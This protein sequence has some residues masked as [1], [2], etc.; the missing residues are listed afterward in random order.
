[1]IY[2]RVTV[3]LYS[4]TRSVDTSR[5]ALSKGPCHF[6]VGGYFIHGTSSNSLQIVSSDP[7]L[8]TRTYRDIP[9]WTLAT[10]SLVIVIKVGNVLWHCSTATRASSGGFNIDSTR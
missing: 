5:A 4:V 2:Q 9:V 1:M 8:N 10:W 7:V 3:D 6:N